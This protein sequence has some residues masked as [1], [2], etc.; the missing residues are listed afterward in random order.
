MDFAQAAR[1]GKSPRVTGTDGRR[2]V[3]LAERILEAMAAHRWTGR[4][5]GP[6]GI[7]G[8]PAPRGPLVAEMRRAA[9]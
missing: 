9:A 6:H 3:E 1:T 8:L 7:K 2:V 5:D 4:V